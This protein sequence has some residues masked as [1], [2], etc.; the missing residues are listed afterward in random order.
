MSK[1]PEGTSTAML[2]KGILLT[3]PALPLEDVDEPLATAIPYRD[4]PTRELPDA[5]WPRTTCGDASTRPG[6]YAPSDSL[7]I[8]QS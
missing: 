1:H 3:M 2:T 4:A 5:V 7:S 6:R 8:A